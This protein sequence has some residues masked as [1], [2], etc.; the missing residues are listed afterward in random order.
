MDRLTRKGVRIGG[1]ALL[2]AVFICGASAESAAQAA[3]PGSG[4]PAE[5][6]SRGKGPTATPAVSSEPQPRPMRYYGGPKSSMWRG[7]ASN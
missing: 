4:S 5:V 7:P 3:G 6:T 1:I 2:A